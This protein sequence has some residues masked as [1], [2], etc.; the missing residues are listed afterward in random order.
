ML[1]NRSAL[2]I[3]CAFS[4]LFSDWYKKLQSAHLLHQ[5]VVRRD[6]F[7]SFRFVQYSILTIQYSF[8]MVIPNSRPPF[9]NDRCSCEPL[10]VLTI[11]RVFQVAIYFRQTGMSAIINKINQLKGK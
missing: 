11:F 3:L 1:R 10:F 9:P 5:R 4:L 7:S 6:S 8:L 2:S